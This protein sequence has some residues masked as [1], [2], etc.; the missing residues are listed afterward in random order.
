LILEIEVPPEL[1]SHD[2][3]PCR[4]TQIAIALTTG[5]ECELAHRVQPDMAF[6]AEEDWG[7]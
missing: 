6:E 5:A 7:R 2:D 3:P 4:V 1:V